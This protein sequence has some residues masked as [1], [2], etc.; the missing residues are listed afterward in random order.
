MH[1]GTAGGHYSHF[2]THFLVLL[3]TTYLQTPKIGC[4]FGR[5]KSSLGWCKCYLVNI[6]LSLGLFS[7]SGNYNSVLVCT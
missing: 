1:S 7:L 5:A 3:M 2:D 4:T 6:V